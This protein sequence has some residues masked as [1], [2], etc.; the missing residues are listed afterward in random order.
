MKSKNLKRLSVLL[1][2]VLVLSQGVSTQTNAFQLDASEYTSKIA[3]ALAALD[4]ATASAAARTLRSCGVT[5][6][7]VGDWVLTLSQLDE[8]IDQLRAGGTPDLSQLPTVGA[9][10]FVVG[11]INQISVN[12]EAPNESILDNPTNPSST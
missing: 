3:S 4:L 11:S 6:I 7:V 9:S 12:C 10:S 5:S 2:T 8:I 1:P